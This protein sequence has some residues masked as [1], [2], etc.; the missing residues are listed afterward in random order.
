MPAG[1]LEPTIS[2]VRSLKSRVRGCSVV[3]A[4]RRRYS[5]CARYASDCPYGKLFLS[6]VASAHPFA[7]NV[8][9]SA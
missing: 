1:V 6:D 7:L 5:M 2:K 8:D 3:I 4:D 9:Q